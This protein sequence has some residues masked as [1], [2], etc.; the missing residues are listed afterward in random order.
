MKPVAFAAFQQRGFRRFFVGNATAMMADNCEHVISYWVMYQKFHSPE[1]G[2]F[3]VISHWVPFLLFSGYS[4][5]LASRIDPRRM[6]QLGMLLFM[7][8]SIAWGLLI[9]TD[10]L[11]VWHAA[12][13]LTVHGC[14][15]VLWGPPSQ[16]LI[17]DI[18]RH[19]QLPSA[20]RLTAT[21]RYVGMLLGP[22]VG[23]GLMLLL[24]PAHGIFANA[25]IYLP[26]L[27]WLWRAPYGPRY[28]QAAG[29]PPALQ[30][31]GDA[32][33]TL[34]SI[35]GNRIILSMTMLAGAVSFFIGNSYQAQMPNFAT[36]LGHG[37]AGVS[38]AALTAAD[39]AG[40]LGAAMMLEARGLLTP[41]VATAFALS[42]LWCC[43]LGIFALT[44]SYAL[45]LWALFCAGF[46]ELA[47]SA[48][49]Q[50]LVQLNA[51]A[52]LRG[53]V[54]GV[55]AMAASGLR[56]VSGF[57]VGILGGLIGVHRSLA[58]AAAALCVV[59]ALLFV[60]L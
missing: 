31:W 5:A 23:N 45:A 52:P 34:R 25:L 46:L 6:I 36:D 59:I 2:G 43:A 1:L 50:A 40:A 49:A 4:G 24:G 19:D 55:Y 41:R 21:A 57:T 14:A 20:V 26:M 18:V 33:A 11:Q 15:G 13:L 38:Y 56:F 8:V 47:F 37:N 58:G 39:A 16:L 51:P 32:F 27:L 10:T 30:G 3:A 53:H 29:A 60:W 12:I 28:R 42:F 17:H 44:H 7:S 22:A 35:R 9:A 48:M 54:I